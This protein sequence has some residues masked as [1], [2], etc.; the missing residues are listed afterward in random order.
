MNSEREWLLE[1]IEERREEMVSLGLSR[2]FADERV[3]RLS[4]QLDQLLNRYQLIEQQE[5]SSSS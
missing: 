5:A 4:D 2:S 1:K 3:V